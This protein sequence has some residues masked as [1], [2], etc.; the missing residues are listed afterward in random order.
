MS[1]DDY[2]E[3]NRERHLRELMDLLRIPSVSTDPARRDDVAACARAVAGRMEEAGLSSQVLPTG[4]H[5][6]VYG[7]WLGSPGAP[8]VLVYGHYDVQPPDPLEEWRHPPFEPT[9]EGGDL[10]ARG[11]TDDKGQMYCHV[12][13]V[14]AHLATSGRLP[15]NVKMLVEGE[16][17]IGSKHLGDFLRAEKARLAADSLVISDSHMFAPGRPTITIGLRG[18]V[19]AEIAVRGPS[20]DL[21]SGLYGGGVVNPALSLGRILACLHDAKGKVAVPGFYDAV[22]DLTAEEREEFRSLGH[23]ESG[24]LRS[25]GVREAPG[26]AGWTLLER[27]TARPTLDVN[28]VWGGYQGPGAKTVIPSVARAKISCRLVPDQDPA[29]VTEKLFAHVREVAG[30]GVTVETTLLHSARA[31]LADRSSAT[32]RAA[33][34]ALSRVWGVPTVFNRSGGSIPIVISFRE[35]L[36]LDAV[37][38][39][40][41]LEDD[42]LHSPNEKFAIDNFFKGIR[43]SAYLFEEL[44]R[45]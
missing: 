22:R 1:I 45:G 25:I 40:L 32:V 7:E 27:I 23:D 31:V 26:E 9:I 33:R 34:R 15:V 37:L 44:A 3:R 42:R 41:G 5:P 11:A 20:H 4:G 28:G 18:L 29:D 19:Y 43:T 6:V 10:V 24:Y 35:I 14:E 36:G 8:T 2:L 17:E 13:G 30:P 16:E 38:A 39:G 21:H 12:K